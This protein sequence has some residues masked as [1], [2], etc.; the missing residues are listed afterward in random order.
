MSATTHDAGPTRQRTVP[1]AA[2][3]VRPQMVVRTRHTRGGPLADFQVIAT[4]GSYEVDVLVRESAV[5]GQLLIRG[6]V[7]LSGFESRP[8]AGIELRLV[9]GELTRVVASAATDEFGQFGFTSEAGGHY[10][11][12]IG[13]DQDAGCVLIWQGQDV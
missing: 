5:P 9:E 7:T 13:G 3:W 10:G 6:Q 11:V 8:A 2:R 4:V 12:Q 1:S